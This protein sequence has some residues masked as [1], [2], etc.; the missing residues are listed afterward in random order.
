[1]CGV[2]LLEFVTPADWSVS[3]GERKDPN[4]RLA[5]LSILIFPLEALE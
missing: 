3:G 1:M 5:E 4:S 2:L